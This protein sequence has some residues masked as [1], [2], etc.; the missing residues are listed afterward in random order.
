MKKSPETGRN[1]AIPSPDHDDF[2]LIQSKIIVIDS[3]KIE[4]DRQISLRNLR[5]L[6]CAGKAAQRATF[7]HP[8]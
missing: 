7:P 2:V 4:R 5:K 1:Y 6:D 8:A 3:D